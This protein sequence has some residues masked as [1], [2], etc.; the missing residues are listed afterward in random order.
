MIFDKTKD[1]MVSACLVC[2]ILKIA[3]KTSML[4]DKIK[5]LMFINIVSK[6]VLELDDAI[7]TQWFSND[8][9][10]LDWFHFMVSLLIPIGNF[11]TEE[12]NM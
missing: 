3:E 2:M 4:S 9:I 10:T 1:N 8:T 7:W 6:Y 11:V 12:A 5:T